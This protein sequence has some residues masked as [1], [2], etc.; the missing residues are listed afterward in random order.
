MSVPRLLVVTAVPFS[1]ARLQSSFNPYASNNTTTS[2]KDSDTNHSNLKRIVVN[3]KQNGKNDMDN[4]WKKRNRVLKNRISSQVSREKAKIKKDLLE[5]Q[6]LELQIEQMKIRLLNNELE[7]RQSKLEE[8]NAILKERMLIGG[9]EEAL[10]HALFVN[11]SLKKK[12]VLSVLIALLG[13]F[14]NS[15]RIP[16]FLSLL[17]LKIQHIVMKSSRQITTPIASLR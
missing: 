10:N 4:S 6:L 12:W 15:L 1:L 14:M 2:F 13:E 11:T 7:V 16:N 17:M 9:M 5:K 8:E 3:S